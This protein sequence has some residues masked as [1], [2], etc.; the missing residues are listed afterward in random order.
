[1]QIDTCKR[2]YIYYICIKITIDVISKLAAGINYHKMIL[3]G[4]YSKVITCEYHLNG[5]NIKMHLEY[6]G[7]APGLHITVKITFSSFNI[8]NK[9]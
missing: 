3:S 5:E 7:N 6:I 9:T 8:G 1:M 2:D 4:I